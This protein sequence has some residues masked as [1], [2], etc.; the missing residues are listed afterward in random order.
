MEMKPVNLSELIPNEIKVRC[1]FVQSALGTKPNKEEILREYITSLAPNG[2]EDEVEAM[3]PEDIDQ[4]VEQGTTVFARDKD[5][6]PIFWDY[7]IR[8]FFKAA[9]GAL[10]RVAKYKMSAHKRVV[11][12]N[13]FIKE[14]QIPVI[15]PA[16][17]EIG[18]CE[19][20]IRVQTPQGERV[21][22]ARSE[23]IP[24]GSYVE[25]TIQIMDKGLRDKIPLW[26][27]YGQFNGLGQWRNAGHGKFTWECV[28]DN[29]TA[30]AG[31][32]GSASAT[33]A[34]PK[35]KRGRKAK[36]EAP[37]ASVDADG[38]AEDSAED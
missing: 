2:G 24:A 7:M 4:G 28:S 38:A 21:A 18:I 26:L 6:R 9:Q 15:V 5:G 33:E 8:G 11:D 25:F 30:D 13:V 36:G 16:D 32:D 17:A 31:T 1:T 10:N 37:A 22:I 23:E 12:T 29:F 20:P 34:K 14:R 35:A 19:R 27:S 3:T